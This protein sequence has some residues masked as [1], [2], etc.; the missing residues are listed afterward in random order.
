M[1]ES[2]LFLKVI[3][4]FIFLFLFS[5][6]SL[7]LIPGDFG[8]AD[9]GPPDGCV[10]FEDL[11]IFALAYGSTPSDS[12]WNPACDIAGLN[13]STTH[14]GC[15]DFEDLMIFAMNYG[16]RDKVTGV[17]AIAITTPY[18]LEPVWPTPASSMI[19]LEERTNKIGEKSLILQNI[20]FDKLKGKEGDSYYGVFIYWDAYYQSGST[21]DIT[22]KVYRSID[23][24]N[25]DNIVSDDNSYLFE[26]YFEG[27]ECIICGF[28]DTDVDPES[29]NTYYYITACGSDWET[30]PSQTVSI[31][32]WLPLC[33]LTSPPNNS[34]IS[35]SNP[36]FTW[37]TGVSNLPYGSIYSGESKLWVFDKFTEWSRGQVWQFSFNDLTTSTATYN[38]DGQATPL[39]S[40]HSYCWN[41]EAYGYDENDHLIA[42]S[43]CEFWCFDYLE[44]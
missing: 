3:I 14:D 22:Y 41:L 4:L 33:V 24:I 34:V 18:S 28:I 38:Q 23:G 44:N 5:A 27:E 15:I 7:A 35:E 43:Y 36:T 32:T 16:R 25:Y 17:K 8:S 20:K 31:E 19:G 30:N 42:L 29:G 37:D 10:D 39:V 13:G 11:M 9:N 40:G 26:E 1:K 6:P 12:N 2:H 21:E